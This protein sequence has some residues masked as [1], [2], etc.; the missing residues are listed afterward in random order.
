VSCSKKT[1]QNRYEKTL[2]RALLSASPEFHWCIEKNCTSG[3]FHA[4]PFSWPNPSR[5]AN[6][7]N[8]REYFQPRHT[9]CK[10]K[11][12]GTDTSKTQ[13]PM[14][15]MQCQECG[16]LQCIQHKCKWHKGETCDEYD[17]RKISNRQ[18]AHDEELSEKR[19]KTLCKRCPGCHSPIEKNK[20]C[21]RIECTYSQ[22]LVLRAYW[23]MGIQRHKM[24]AHILL[25]LSCLLPRHP[26]N[27]K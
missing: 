18:H 10:R 22:R 14:M 2:T 21:D 25:A 15:Q 19:K 6:F 4:L 27:R 24:L 7:L 13:C 11:D 9:E 8:W 20:G 26:S 5:R 3:Q 12:L 17:T 23:L 1:D 16:L